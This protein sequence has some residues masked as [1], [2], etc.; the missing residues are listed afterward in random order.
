MRVWLEE[1]DRAD[2]D[3]TN[4]YPPEIGQRLIYVLGVEPGR[5]GSPPTGVLVVESAPVLRVQ[6]VA[7][8][9]SGGRT[10][11]PAIEWC[12]KSRD[13]GFGEVEGGVGGARKQR[14]GERCLARRA[15]PET[16]GSMR[17]RQRRRKRKPVLPPN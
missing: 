17:T 9:T 5:S 10:V 13:V 4:T 3:T 14:L 7:F 1:L 15:A 12:E 8:V 6:L 2:A 11:L 16:R